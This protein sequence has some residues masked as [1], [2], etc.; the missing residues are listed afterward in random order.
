MPG[1]EARLPNLFIPD[2]GFCREAF[3]ALYAEMMEASHRTARKG[4]IAPRA[5]TGI[6]QSVAE[7][8]QPERWPTLCPEISCTSGLLAT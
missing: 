8:I 1:D 2:D 7:G 6:F 3:L 4:F 5:S